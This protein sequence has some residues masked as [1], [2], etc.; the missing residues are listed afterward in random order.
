MKR[1][2]LLLSAV[3]FVV[4]SGV[5]SAAE[6]TPDPLT[7]DL[8]LVP[9]SKNADGLNYHYGEKLD[10]QKVIS[11]E[12]DQSACGITPA[13]MTYQ[14]SRGEQHTVRY[15]IVGNGCQSG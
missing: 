2:A 12:G 5:V 14:D 9:P 6:V 4:M 8:Q 11:I 13:L 15:Q 7:A 10:I 3:P 1:F